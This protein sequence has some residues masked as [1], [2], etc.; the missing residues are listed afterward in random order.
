M[1]KI[2][3][4]N[5]INMISSLINNYTK[6]EKMK[7]SAFSLLKYLKINIYSIYFLIKIN[8]NIHLFL[9]NVC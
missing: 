9:K 4:Y 3:Y 6:G 1:G 7:N 5:Y 8:V 2:N